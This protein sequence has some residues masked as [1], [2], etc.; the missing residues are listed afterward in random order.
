MD[1]YL[2]GGYNGNC[3]SLWRKVLDALARGGDE[4]NIYL[5]GTQGRRWIVDDYIKE[6]LKD[7]N[8][9]SRSDAL[10]GQLVYP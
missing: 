7:A 2:A 6:Y 4:L 5:A 1:I 9:S 3:S 10:G 8:L